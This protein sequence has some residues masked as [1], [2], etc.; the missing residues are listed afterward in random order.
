MIRSDK[1]IEVGDDPGTIDRKPQIL[2]LRVIKG[3]R[4]RSFEVGSYTIDSYIANLADTQLF[5]KIFL[6][7]FIA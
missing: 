6:Y 4:R 3:Q 2:I 1:D 5:S 7:I